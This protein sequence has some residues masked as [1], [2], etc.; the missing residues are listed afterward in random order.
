MPEGEVRATGEVALSDQV[1]GAYVY[2]PVAKRSHENRSSLSL[3]AGAGAAIPLKDAGELGS[4]TL[5]LFI[6][7]TADPRADVPIATLVGGGEVAPEAGLHTNY[8]RRWKQTYLG[9]RFRPAAGKERLW[10]AGYYL[11]SG[12]L[13][14]GKLGWR[15]VALV[16]D[17]EQGELTFWLD[18]HQ[19]SSTECETPL[20]FEDAAL[21]VGGR[22][23]GRGIAGRIDEVRLTRGALKPTQFLRARRDAIENVTFESQAAVMPEDAGY[24][25]L[26]LAFGAAGD[27]KTDDTDAIQRAFEQLANKVPLREHVLYIPPGEYLISDEVRW[28]RFLFVQG[29]GRDQTILKLKDNCPGYGN[30]D[31][32]KGAL[33]VAWHDFSP[34]ASGKAGNNIGSYLHDMTIDTGAGNP[35]AVALAYH[36]NNHGSVTNVTIRSGDGKGFAGLALADNW[37]GP[38]LI[39]NMTIRGFDK[40]VYSIVGQYSITFKDLTLEGQNE[41]GLYNRGQMVWIDG[42]RSRNRVPAVDMGG[43]YVLVDAELTGG[44]ADAPAIRLR[45]GNGL[46]RDVRVEGYATAVEREDKSGRRTLDGPRVEEAAFGE[47]T[48]VFDS[49]KRSLNLP[50]KDA[51]EPPREAPEKWVNILDFE[52][53][54]ADG[55]WAPAVQAAVDSGARTL[56][57]P[58][59][60]KVEVKSPVHIRGKAE[61]LFGLYSGIRPHKEYGEGPTLIYD[62]PDAKHVLV[63]DRFEA[64]RLHHASPGTLI[65]RD[66]SPRYTNEPGAGELYAEGT[67]GRYVITEQRAWFWQL[68]TEFS[69]GAGD[70]RLVNR[71]GQV[72][73]V[74]MKTEQKGAN[75]LTAA[76]GKTELLGGF[77]YANSG[78]GG[79]PSIIIDNAAFSGTWRNPTYG[80]RY[81]P[82]VRET[83]DDRTKGGGTL[84]QGL[85]TGYREAD[86]PK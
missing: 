32:P 1:P 25:D 71:G 45:G 62:H 50:L 55:D 53:Q 72:V 44:A 67:L 46:L 6:H 31:D 63:I 2:D 65:I 16:Y 75:I 70:A 42:L 54:V 57:L 15:H 41:V 84:Y 23:G 17:A 56:Y 74:G 78:T 28:T 51:P 21:H 79:F 22:A 26:K 85:Y 81:K 43:T 47:Q 8:L 39:K 77:F 37:P 52:G 19:T 83:R 86:A 33:T 76:G 60:K 64:G 48:S 11:G 61:R 13:R 12:R 24:V 66:A 3:A 59:C 40:G 80:G 18:H 35:G 7:P 9:A 14:G 4:F 73:V 5:E 27:G 68:N 20:R 82:V 29:A 30:P 49:P 34:E 69:T 10:N 58:N 36:S 38:S